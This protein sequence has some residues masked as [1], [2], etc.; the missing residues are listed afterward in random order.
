MLARSRLQG[1][2]HQPRLSRRA[3]VSM[4]ASCLLLPLGLGCEDTTKLSM[5]RAAEHVAELCSVV[6]QD[7]A[8]VRAGL[9]K[10]AALMAEVYAAGKDP[11][12]DPNGVAKALARVRAKVQ[13]LRVAKSNFFALVEP[14][15][16]VVR[17]DQEQDRLV[18][19]ALLKH[20]PGLKAALGG[21]YVEALG[22]MPEAAEVDKSRKDGQWV[23]A[24]PVVVDDKP[25]GLYVTGWSWVSYADRMEFRL[26]GAVRTQLA[27]AP[28]GS[29]NEP[30]IYV[31]VIVGERAY[32]GPATAVVS[33]DAIA[34]LRLLGKLDRDA[35]HSEV[36][37]LTGRKY[38]LAA[39]RAPALGK[40]IAVVVL[41]SE[42]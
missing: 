12:D 17:S 21:K 30:L 22:S 3:L 26:R 23:A 13:E 42:T 20:Y 1:A 39:K 16:S 29:Q 34:K 11:A 15:G 40:D 41:R 38:G 28:Q 7:V 36:I 31:F 6:E 2:R 5:E 35:V 33:M 25:R 27:D 4:L 37:E 18:S 24:S 8:E 9:P 32:G 10:G 14:G 19:R